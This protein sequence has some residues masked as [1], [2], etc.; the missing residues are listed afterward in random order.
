[1]L[2]IWDL[3][4]GGAR[5]TLRGHTDR[6]THVAIT[7]DGVSAISASGD[8]TLI[9]WDLAS[10]QARHTLIGHTS[11]V[12]HVAITPDGASAVSAS[13]DR[14]LIIWDLACGEKQMQVEATIEGRQA[15]AVA[16]PGVRA[17]SGFMRLDDG[18]QLI[19]LGNSL[20]VQ[21]PG[22][23]AARWR[24]DAYIGSAQLLADGMVVAGDA[25]GRV[26]FLRYRDGYT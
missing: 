11:E 26:I 3:A 7:S 10:G 14:T 8:R 13:R 24:G 9:V 22:G 6:V 20:Y 5:H 15:L 4:S 19:N 23:L 21:H 17:F 1:M 25:A 12:T 16:Y 2:I 18:W